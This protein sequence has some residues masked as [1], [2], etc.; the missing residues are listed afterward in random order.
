MRISVSIECIY[1]SP[2]QLDFFLVHSTCRLDVSAKKAKYK[3]KM[4]FHRNKIKKKPNHERSLWKKDDPVDHD[5]RK[6]LVTTNTVVSR[7][8]DVLLSST[9][10]VTTM[11]SPKLH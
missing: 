2:R 5:K 6:I 4:S 3:I 10:L 9:S 8:A 1:Y 7:K 11:T